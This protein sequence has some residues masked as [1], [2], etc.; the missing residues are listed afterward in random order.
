MANLIPKKVLREI[1]KGRQC[2]LTSSGKLWNSYPRPKH[3]CFTGEKIFEVTSPSSIEFIVS[4]GLQ[5]KRPLITKKERID[6]EREHY[7]GVANDLGR[8]IQNELENE[9]EI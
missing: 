3:L 5:D 9:G 1:L 2:I 4:I 7:I 8:E 6:D